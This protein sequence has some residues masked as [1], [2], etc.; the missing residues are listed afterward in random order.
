MTAAGGADGRAILHLNAGASWRDV[1][2]AELRAG[3][4]VGAVAAG[5][6]DGDGRTDLVIGYL[7]PEGGVWRAGID[8]LVAR[9]AGFERRELL[10]EEGRN[11]VRALAVGD[12]D[13]D[14][15]HEVVAVRGDGAVQVMAAGGSG[16]GV[17]VPPPDWRRGCSGY[18]LRLADLDG[19]GRPEI[20]ASFAGEASAFDLEGGC[21][22]GGGIQAWTLATG[23]PSQ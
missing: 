18:G 13:G 23:Q 9:G 19:D 11:H 10:R 4:S 5:D 21:R 16:P 15:H 1:E 17:L 12:L 20:V 14:R 6:L 2:V 8:L 22:S 7:D 3:A